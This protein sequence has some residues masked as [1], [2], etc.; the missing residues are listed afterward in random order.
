MKNNTTFLKTFQEVFELI[1]KYNNVEELQDGEEKKMLIQYV[2]SEEVFQM[3]TR[4]EVLE[5]IQKG[6][7]DLKVKK[8]KRV[9]VEK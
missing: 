2:T 5:E 4:N 6:T 3:K 9:R 1:G 7:L 8:K